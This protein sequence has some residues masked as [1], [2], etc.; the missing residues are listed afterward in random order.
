MLHLLPCTN[1]V[2]DR[3]DESVCSVARQGC[4]GV[5]ACVCCEEGGEQRDL[6][7]V[8]V[9]RLRLIHPCVDLIELG[10]AVV[11]ASRAYDEV[12]DVFGDLGKVV[13]FGQP[14][15]RKPGGFGLVSGGIPCG[16][17]QTRRGMKLLDQAP[18]QLNGR[19]LLV[20]A[21][22]EPVENEGS[23]ALQQSIHKHRAQTRIDS[24]PEPYHHGKRQRL[25]VS[26]RLD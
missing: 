26:E 15:N 5:S 19:I 14:G 25:S 16:H 1:R 24:Q 2:L 13:R 18:N 12:Q 23:V 21:F 17:D 7:H 6:P 8:G 4:G 22:V 20:T 10:R 3:R 9:I 11:R